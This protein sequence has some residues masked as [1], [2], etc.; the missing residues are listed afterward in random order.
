MVINPISKTIP[1]E[2]HII[3][4]DGNRWVIVWRDDIHPRFGRC[5]YDKR[6]MWI[7]CNISD[8]AQKFIWYHEMYHTGDKAKNE[9]WRE[10]KAN[11]YAGYKRPKG[12]VIVLF[13]TLF[14]LSRLKMYISKLKFI[15]R[16]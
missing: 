7:N 14:S 13:M 4:N 3:A 5:I 9:L 16:D 11:V 2:I 15:Q 8:S 1:G 12:F 6:E 10:I